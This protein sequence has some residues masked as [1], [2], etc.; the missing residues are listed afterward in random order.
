MRFLVDQN[1]SPVIAER[2]RSAGHD[3]V[4][5]GDLDLA[6][7]IPSSAS[8]VAAG[9]LLRHGAAFDAL[10]DIHQS[11]GTT[12]RAAVLEVPHELDQF[13]TSDLCRVKERDTTARTPTFRGFPRPAAGSD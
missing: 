6:M 4:H 5:T 9:L 10:G 11:P 3:V 13:R 8:V 12:C 7:E 2:L 1:L